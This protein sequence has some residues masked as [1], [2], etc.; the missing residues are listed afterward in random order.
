MKRTLFTA[1]ALVALAACGKSD[2]AAPDRKEAA[3]R[4]DMR[5]DAPELGDFGVDLSAMDAS[6]APGDDFYDYVNGAWLESFKM[7]DDYSSYGSFTVLAERSE[8]RLREIIEGIS[9]NAPANSDEQRARDFYAAYNDIETINAKGL[10]PL[11]GDLAMI[12]ALASAEEFMAAS[13][14]AARRATSPIGVRIRV[15]AKRPDRY[16]IYLTQSGLGM[17]NR[18]YYLEDRFADKQAKY[19]A[20]IAAILSLAGHD[21]PQGGADRIYAL[22]QAIARVHWEPSKQR[23]RDL[24]YNL[25]TIEQ[26][27]AYAP[28][29]PW[30]DMLDRAGLGGAHEVVLRED[31]AIRNIASIVATTPIE[32]LRDYFRFHLINSNADILPS[33][34]DAANFAFFR[35]ELRGA[36]KQKERWKRAIDAVDDALG[37]AV[38]KI[39]VERYFPASSKTQMAGLVD[40]L[41]AAL[42]AQIE[43][44]DWMSD[45]TRAKALDKLSKLTTK[46][47]YPDKWRS[48]DGLQ[49][50]ADDAYGNAARA[51]KFQWEFEVSRLGGP[52]DRSEWRMTP[53]TV[54]A[55]YSPALNEIVF[56]AAI[57][58]PPFFDPNADPAVNYGAIGAVIGHEIGH[59]FDDQGRKSNGDG[60]LVDWW[61]AADADR[62]EERAGRLGAQYAG[63][64][65][66]EGFPVD[67]DLTMGENIGDLGGLA[68]AYRAYRLS[69][70]E[71]QAPV[72]D[73]LTGDQRFFLSWAQVWKRAVRD[74][75]LKNQIASDPHAPAAFRVNGV[76]RN[77][78]AWYEAFGVTPENALWLDPEDRVRIW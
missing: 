53:Q 6:V 51:A 75:H 16:A 60:V 52:V 67:P 20:Y 31:D 2:V 27:G 55:S 32:T 30:R 47:G 23:N 41:R 56:P 14:D 5:A 37:E 1:F 12:D 69:L 8:N 71:N 62:F 54:N 74:D 76:V 17:P 35:T 49:I 19:R 13:F 4:K 38:G 46:I 42:G 77:M 22:E 33:N 9:P 48:Y 28:A 10:S 40:N 73:A 72:I 43:T 64:E 11:A 50:V 15:D 61:T 68:M 57:L 58:Q 70:G 34:F 29:A 18:D 45:E 21:D 25:K 24:T 66:I 26:L 39:Y 36:P 7:P 78:D 59:G 63:Y 44:I 3:S 65:P